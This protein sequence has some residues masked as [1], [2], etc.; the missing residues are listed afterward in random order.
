MEMVRDGEEEV[1]LKYLAKS[2]EGWM[3]YSEDES[4]DAELAA[5]FTRKAEAIEEEIRVLED[6]H[7]QMQAELDRVIKDQPPISE[8][9]AKLAASG[10]TIQAL[11]DLIRAL[12]DRTAKLQ[13]TLR[14]S[15]EQVA[16]M[17]APHW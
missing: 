7:R 5:S 10:K 16:A 17:G 8:M 15:G 2:Y 14:Q 3:N 6:N 1:F 4:L 12:R 11:E 9:E 13:Q